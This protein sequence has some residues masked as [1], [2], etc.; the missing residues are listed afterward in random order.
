MSHYKHITP[1]KCEKI[2]LLHSQ[3][4]TITYI[5]DSSGRDKSTISRE[6]SRNTVD[7]KYMY[8]LL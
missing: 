4:C 5:A 2:L 3:N 8:N 6:L 1:E 7:N